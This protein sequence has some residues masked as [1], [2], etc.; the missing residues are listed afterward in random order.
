[1]VS[2]IRIDIYLDLGVVSIFVY[3]FRLVFFFGC[4]FYLLNTREL[5]FVLH[6]VYSLH[7]RMNYRD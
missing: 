2:F 6:V 4:F 5:H 7:R 1:M 3:P